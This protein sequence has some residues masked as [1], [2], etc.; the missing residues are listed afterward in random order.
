V[1]GT[2]SRWL[3]RV[4]NLTSDTQ[5]WLGGAEQRELA[6]AAVEDVLDDAPGGDASGA[7]HGWEFTGGAPDNSI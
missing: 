1:S 5:V 6:D 3:P 2:L 4:W 7:W